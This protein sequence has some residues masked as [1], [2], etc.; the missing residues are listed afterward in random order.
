MKWEGEHAEAESLARHLN[1]IGIGACTCR[2]AW[3]PLGRLHEISMGH[4]WARMTTA[5]NCPVH[6]T[7]QRYTASMR[8]AQPAWSNPY[9]P[10][11]QTNDCP[12][13][14]MSGSTVI[15]VLCSATYDEPKR[16]DRSDTHTC[17]LPDVHDGPHHCAEC[18]SYWMARVGV[19]PGPHPEREQIAL[20]RM[21]AHLVGTGYVMINRREDG[22]PTPTGSTPI[23]V[24][25][26]PAE[27]AEVDLDVEAAVKS[28]VQRS[29]RNIKLRDKLA[30]L[31]RRYRAAQG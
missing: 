31:I 1:F 8:A 5:A 6:D 22:G 25:L 11:H 20:A 7:C 4:G 10:I 28:A 15:A 27:A 12:E 14:E 9:C 16:K 18:D 23:R 30:L 13:P 29:I 26:L 17:D 2:F 3:K 19:V 21:D 24:N